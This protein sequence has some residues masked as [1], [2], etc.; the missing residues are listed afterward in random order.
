MPDPHAEAEERGSRVMRFGAAVSAVVLSSVIATMPAAVRIAPAVVGSCG[1]T[2][3]WLALLAL[4]F[5]PL[6]IATVTLRHALAAM[7]L[8]DTSAIAAGVAT[9]VVWGVTT[10][11]GLAGLGAMLRATTH[12]HGLGG[13]TFAG[14]GLTFAAIVAI[15]ARR[16]V[17]VCLAASPALRWLAIGVTSVG[18]GVL[19]A[20]FARHVGHSDGVTV[21]AVDLVAFLFAAAFGAGAFPYRSRPFAALAF[22]GPPLAVVVLV[23]GLGTLRSSAP[24]R[25]A[26]AEDAP[27]L[28]AAMGA[29]RMTV[30][31]SP[32]IA[33]GTAP[34]M[35]PD[36]AATS[37]AH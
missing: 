26:I 15:F 34:G 27:V 32:G 19:L 25:T 5:V 31:M 8:F 23:L 13:V 4:A 12:H 9:A 22:S 18:M 2:T 6:A 10:F 29:S 30:G 37:S 17:D 7:R 20:S 14:V 11:L 21:F 16:F 35:A 36:G 28:A 1:A 3:V 33:P 24:L